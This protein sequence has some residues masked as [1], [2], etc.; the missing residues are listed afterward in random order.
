MRSMSI[1]IAMGRKVK[2][3]Q[4]PSSGAMILIWVELMKV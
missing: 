4:D 2:D 3:D 1:V